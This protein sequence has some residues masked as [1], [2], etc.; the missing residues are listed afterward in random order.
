MDK[1]ERVQPRKAPLDWLRAVHSDTYVTFFGVSPTACLKMV[2]SCRD[3]A[4]LPLSNFV[5]LSCGG[6]GVDSDTY[7][8]D[9]S[10]QA[11]ARLAAGSVA[12]LAL[13][14][15][16]GRLLNGFAVVRPPGHH[17]ERDQ[18]MGFCYFN[19]VAVAARLLL[20]RAAAA[21]RAPPRI[22][23]PSSLPP[24]HFTANLIA[25]IVDWDV[26]HG[27]GTQLAFE[28]DPNVLYLSL[29]RHDNGNFFPGTGAVTDVGVPP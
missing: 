8:N 5:R 22:G 24:S 28:A 14:V 21:G 19:N 26:H 7:F 2:E 6:Y 18:A 1:C 12:Q 15:A 10:T 4:Q 27:N 13:S 23:R 9:A 20:A 16:E 17:A 29:H 11:A 3:P 25:A